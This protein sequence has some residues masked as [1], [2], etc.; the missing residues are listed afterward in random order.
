MSKA[1]TRVCSY[2]LQNKCNKDQCNF[3]HLPTFDDN[4]LNYDEIMSSND[5]IKVILNSLTEAFINYEKESPYMKLKSNL[6]RYHFTCGCK[7]S[8]DECKDKYKYF[9]VPKNDDSEFDIDLIKSNQTMINSMIDTLIELNKIHFEYSRNSQQ[10]QTRYQYNNDDMF[11]A[12]LHG[13][14]DVIKGKGKGGKNNQGKGN[15]MFQGKGDFKGKGNTNNTK[16]KGKGKGKNK[17][18]GGDVDLD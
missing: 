18:K 2:F 11:D 6:C 5:T 9:H 3:M 10:P 1:N 17:G 12:V 8:D 7:H 13:L 15:F 16:G 4:K 14:I